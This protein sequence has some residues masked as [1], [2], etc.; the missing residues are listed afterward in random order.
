MRLGPA[1]FKSLSA[2]AFA[3]SLT[4]AATPLQADTPKSLSPAEARSFALDLLKQGQNRAAREVALGLLRQDSRDYLALMVLADAEHRLGRTEKAK[5]A[6]RRAWRSTDVQ[7]ERFAAAYLM[8]NILRTEQRFGASQL[9][10]R[11]AGQVADNPRFEQAAKNAYARVRAQNPWSIGFGFRFSPTSNVNGGPNDNTYTIGDLVFVDPTAVP[12]SGYEIGA[13]LDVTRRLKPMDWGQVSFGIGIDETT[14]ILSNSAKAAVPTASGSDYAFRTVDFNIGI[15]LPGKS[16]KTLTEVDVKFGRNWQAGEEL[17]DFQLV[18]LSH[19]RAGTRFARYGYGLTLQNQ[20]RLDRPERS[21]KTV[22][23]DAY[24]L[25]K[26][27]NGDF[28]RYGISLAKVDSASSDMAHASLG[29]SLGYYRAEP[30]LGAK[31]SFTAA[32]GLREYDELRFGTT[33]RRDQKLTL[34]A[35]FTFEQ[36]DYLGFSPTLKLRGTRNF[37]NKTFFDSQEFGLSLGVKSTF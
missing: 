29:L 32:L 6:A 5:F 24:A 9:W 37:S 21:T 35:D 3:L 2:L 18:R 26:R 10:L 28:L 12:L 14:Y 33:L 36:I 30:I 1:L 15:D 20:T 25:Q 7:Q 19:A 13:S 27:A 11:R 17:A 22:A 31:V 23:V 4:C 16:S 8:S 34:S